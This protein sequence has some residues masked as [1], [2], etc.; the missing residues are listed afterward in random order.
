MRLSIEITQEQHKKLKATAA[1]QGKAIKD[2]V[3]ERALPDTEEET[4][5]RAL[6]DFLKPRVDAAKRGEWTDQTVTQIVADALRE[7][8]RL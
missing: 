7:E 4:A 6:E 8:P 3:L 1:M 5:L 2:F